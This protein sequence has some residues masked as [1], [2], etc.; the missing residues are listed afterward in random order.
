MSLKSRKQM[1]KETEQEIL[2]Y[3]RSQPE[4]VSFYKLYT[5]LNYTSGKAQTALKRLEVDGRIYLRKKISKFQTFVSDNEFELEPKIIKNLDEELMVFPFSINYAVGAIL[6]Q[7]PK[8]TDEF[9]NFIDIVKKAV[10]YY[11]IEKIPHELRVQAVH[12]AIEKGKIPEELGRQ[13]LGE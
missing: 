1:K 5:D 10:E 12:R 6:K 9:N 4:H 7:L 8:L 13:I 11:F 2:D 3:L